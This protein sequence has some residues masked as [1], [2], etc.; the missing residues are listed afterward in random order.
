[1]ARTPRRWRRP[2]APSP[3]THSTASAG[4]S[5]IFA[6]RSQSCPIMSFDASITAIPLA[7]AVRLPPVRKV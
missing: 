3:S 5:Q 7:N 1:M 4:M 6:A 2:A